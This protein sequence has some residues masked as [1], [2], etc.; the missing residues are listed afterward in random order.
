M[1]QIL[2]GVWNGRIFDN[3]KSESP[4]EGFPVDAIAEFDP[5]NPMRALVAHA[6]FLVLDKT[7]SLARVLSD[8]YKAVR[9]NSCGRCTPC[10]NASVIID[11]ALTSL[12]V[13]QEATVDWDA[14]LSA[15]REMDQ[16][17]LCGIGRTSAKPL[18]AALTH[19]K[20]ELFKTVTDTRMLSSYGVVTTSCIE[21][22][23]DHVNIPRYMDFVR[24]GQNA[25]ARAVILER[26]PMVA[27]CGRVCVRPCEKAC[28]RNALE[29]PLAIKEVK[30]YIA[31][32]TQGTIA[33]LFKK[34]VPE[35]ARAQVAVVGAGPA[36]I[37]C[38]Y[39]L[40]QKGVAVD[41]YDADTESGGMALRGIPPYRLPKDILK[42][43]TDAVKSLG[44]AFFYGKKLGRDMSLADLKARYKAVFL[45]IG[46]AEGAYLG[47]PDEDTTLKGYRNGIDFLLEIEKEVIAGRRP[48]MDGDIAVVGCGNVAMD[49]CR[50]ARRVTTG[51]VHLIYRRT[52][53]EAPADKEEIREAQEEGVEFHFLTNPVAL[54]SRDGVLTGVRLTKMHTTE[55]D[56]RGRMGVAPVPGSE[57]TLACQTLVA[58]IGQK[59]ETQALENSGLTLGRRGNIQTDATQMTDV[60]G[61]FA[62]G[63]CATG[64]TSLVEALA[65]GD[66]AAKSI[67]AYLKGQSRFNPRDRASDLI[68]RL[69]LVWDTVEPC[70]PKKR[71]TIHRVDPAV[72]S[73]NF[74][75]ADTGFTDAEACEEASRCMRCY[76]VIRFYTDK[77][78]ANA[79]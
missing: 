43:E 33:S 58:A 73:K 71:M 6:G 3:R 18:I 45:G 53:K 25:L 49:C 17:S 54:E 22:C 7:V 79:D 75:P 29:G 31:E 48:K 47:L 12:A 72:R 63:D 14:V 60:D 65:Q 50:T 66:R 34:T 30:R 11:E 69:K 9:A 35:G 1:A 37:N 68:M 40:L 4:S 56:A 46:C 13:S 57:F 74:Y 27:T 70:K 16:T 52:L 21:G 51:R 78:V 23:P 19:F 2:Y 59:I 55:P 24:D 64:P 5:N 28:R 32:A 38:A 62:G 67:V 44:G 41:I 26:Y 76:R 42:N 61:V 77:P 10:R 20:D 15:A 39:H 36:G 8:Y